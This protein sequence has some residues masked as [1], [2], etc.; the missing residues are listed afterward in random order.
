MTYAWTPEDYSTQE[1]VL[2]RAESQLG[3]RYNL[4]NANCED[5]VNWIIT[6]KAR[7]PQRENAFALTI[8]AGL[9]LALLSGL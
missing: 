3:R 6:G 8:V 2:A 9:V 4:F 1:A 7:S 5:L